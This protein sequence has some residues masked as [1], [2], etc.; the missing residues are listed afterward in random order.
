MS[1]FVNSATPTQ[2]P[3]EPSLIV[4]LCSLAEPVLREPI[5]RILYSRSAPAVAQYRSRPAT[6]MLRAPAGGHRPIQSP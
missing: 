3:H 2:A 1:E 4:C 6:T 5:V